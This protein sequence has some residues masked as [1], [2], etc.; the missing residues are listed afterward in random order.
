VDGISVGAPAALNSSGVAT[1]TTSGLPAG[2]RTITADYGGDTNFSSSTGALAVGQVVG[3]VFEFSQDL[4]SVSERGGSVTITVG[5][6]GDTSGTVSV[7]YATDDGSIPSVAVPCASVTGL[8]LERCDYTRAAG[9]LRFTAGE[10][11]KT[12]SVLVNDDSSAE[13]TET[14]QLR[15]SNPAGG[16]ALGQQSSATLRI[17]DDAQQSSN[18]VDDSRFYARQHYHDFLNREPDDPGLQFWTNES[19]SCGADLRCREVKRINVSAAFSLSIEFQ[20]TGYLVERM[21]KVAYGDTVSPNVPIPVPVIRLNEFLADTQRI[22]RGVVVGEGNWQQQLEDNKNGFAAEFV[23][24]QKFANAYPSSL[25]ANEFVTRL[26]ANTGVGLADAERAQ[27]DGVFG[28][29][30]ASSADTAK[31]AQVLRE[32][33]EN[34]QF[35][36]SESNRAFVL[37][38]YFGYLR[39][40]PDDAPDSDFSGWK[41]WLDKLNQFDGNYVNAEMVKAFLTSTEYRRRFG[42]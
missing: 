34:P 35:R 22:S 8:A 5:R 40:N 37:M 20:E 10:T 2:A 41:F 28:G 42:P 11:Q 21:Y 6:A 36:Q 29:P 32:V 17:L 4:Y 16:A 25:T 12:F 3:A 18:P 14:A 9:T 27:L 7:D 19:E 26:G 38:Q 24:R 31:R 13:G 30:A 33:A 39:R 1:F 23:S 15:L